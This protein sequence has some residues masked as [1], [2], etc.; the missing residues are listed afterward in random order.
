MFLSK[1]T[2][3]IL[4]SSLLSTAMI[5]DEDD[6]IMKKIQNSISEEG[7]L[8]SFF[9]EGG[10]VGIFRNY[11]SNSPVKVKNSP[12]FLGTV[13]VSLFPESLKLKISYTSVVDENFF[14]PDTD[15]RD[16]GSSNENVE[17]IDIFLKP[18]RTEYGSLGFGFKKYRYNTVLQNIYNGQIG[19]TDIPN[20]GKNP[21]GRDTEGDVW[22]EYGE[23]YSVKSY[24]RR[25]TVMYNLPK[26]SWLPEGFGISYSKEKGSRPFV[27]RDNVAVDMHMESERYGIGIYKTFDELK[28]DGFFLKNLEL[29]QSKMIQDKSHTT[30]YNET[31]VREGTFSELNSKSEF[32]G[33]SA[34]VTYKRKIKSNLYYANFSI[35]Y[36]KSEWTDNSRDDIPGVKVE[37]STYILGLKLGVEFM[38]I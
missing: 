33:L 2:K 12:L 32:M 38:G 29:Y 9:V 16:R 3:V 36:I 22:L 30:L 31:P 7:K 24:F 28:G 34:E 18:I 19:V 1:I 5:A 15:K 27:L 8:Y 4:I 17:L 13:G 26:I 10:V 6:S 23:K 14:S 20:D 25:Y 21:E 11:S 35:D 37:E